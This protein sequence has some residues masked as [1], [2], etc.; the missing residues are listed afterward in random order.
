MK[1]L[2]GLFF[3]LLFTSVSAQTT[4]VLFGERNLTDQRVA[5]YFDKEGSLYPSYSISDSSLNNSNASLLKWYSDH[6]SEFLII[7]KIYTCNFDV[8]NSVNAA[9]LNDSIVMATKR[10][11][12]SKKGDFN[13]ISFLI[14]GYRKPFVKQNG[15]R[16]SPHDYE[17]LEETI[18]KSL[19]TLPVEVYWD[20]MYDCCFS[21]HKR[22]NDELYDLLK[23][24]EKNS[25]PVGLGLRKVIYSLNFDTVN[26]ITHS[27]GAKVALNTCFDSQKSVL[28]RPINKCVNLCLIAPAI[29]PDDVYSKFD[30]RSKDPGYNGK[31]NFR[32]LIGYNEHDF[33]LRKKV[34]WFGPGP[35][36]YVNTT[37]GCNHNNCA[38]ELLKS[39][40]GKSFNE[41]IMLFDLSSVGQ[42]HLVG[43]Y[44]SSDHLAEMLDYLR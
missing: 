38:P 6:P 16:T 26:L 2:S 30:F 14:H 17:I 29:S 37:L 1:A 12:H 40:V 43:C 33:V 15:D 36:R 31:D 41:H 18:Q 32:L 11:L 28:P 20:A 42:C 8:Y 27:L 10:L 34:G 21:T 7:S 25:L 13:S 44:C 3:L 35:Y 39:F 24:A 19:K 9:I 5:V 4:H 22:K 23:E